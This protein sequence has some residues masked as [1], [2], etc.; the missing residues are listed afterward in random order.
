MC[1][2]LSI[3]RK[4]SGGVAPQQNSECT[5]IDHVLA[6]TTNCCGVAIAIVAAIGGAT[7]I[8]IAA[9]AYIAHGATIIS[10]TIA[11]PANCIMRSR[12]WRCGE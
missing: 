5:T 9:F 11:Y 10:A 8:V 6:T 4:L 12:G 7:D 3:L 1:W 2:R